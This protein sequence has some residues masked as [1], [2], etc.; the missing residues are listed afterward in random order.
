MGMQR[1]GQVMKYLSI[2]VLMCGLFLTFLA[3]MALYRADVRM[4]R[5]VLTSSAERRLNNFYE[6]VYRYE[7]A[8]DIIDSTV[9]NSE[10]RTDGLG[11]MSRLLE[12]DRSIRLIE[13]IPAEGDSTWFSADRWLGSGRSMLEGPLKEAALEARRERKSVMV[14][15]LSLDHERT[16]MAVL[17]PIFLEDRAS[18]LFWGYVLIL[19]SQESVLRNSNI[20]H[21]DGMREDYRLVREGNGTEHVL[22]E[23]GT[24]SRGDPSASVN[25]G[26]DRWTLTLRPSQ[27]WLNMQTLFLATLCGIMGSVFIS[28]LWKKNRILKVIGGTDSLTGVYNRKGGDKAVAAYLKAHPGEPAMVMA[29]DIDNFKLINDVYG[30]GAGDRAL[31]VLVRDMRRIFGRETIITR[32]GGDEFILFHPFR[33]KEDVENKMT[34]FTEKP[35][36][37]QAD[38]RDVPFHSS[39]GCAEYPLQGRE[40]GKL[41]VRADFALYAVKLNGK[42]GW[43][44]FDDTVAENKHRTQFGFNLS[45]VAGSMP[46]GMLVCKATE[47]QE[48]LFANRGMIDLLECDSFE[49]FM[50][51]TGGTFFSILYP[52]EEEALK[53]EFQRQLDSRDNEK[54]TD[55][56]TFRIVTKKGRV[57]TV[58]DVGRKKENPFY[59]ELYYIFMYDRAEREERQRG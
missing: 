6:Y 8:A 49:D 39:M 40:Y 45:E 59:G 16:Y 12:I 53:K 22:A 36:I 55:F 23:E 52:G 34:R 27:G 29:L 58:E 50:H 42:A 17:Q 30:H 20:V 51:Y 13:V 4:E 43:R 38:G 26:G 48:I 15:S 10:G 56:L 18:S 47:D 44:R 24:V 35:H 46:G 57:I 9:Q 54:Q 7:T 41:C 31:K 14:D 3:D 25:I 32:N 33:N 28:L 19:G 2:P 11:G 1:I 5:E 21:D 37:I